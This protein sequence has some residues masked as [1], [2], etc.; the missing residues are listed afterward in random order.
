[1]I[2]FIQITNLNRTEITVGY[3]WLQRNSKILAEYDGIV[4]QA[5]VSKKDAI[6]HVPWTN[7]SNQP[8]AGDHSRYVKGSFPLWQPES[9][10]FKI[11]SLHIF[12]IFSDGT[13]TCIDT[14]YI[15]FSTDSVSA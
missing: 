8:G 10:L 6:V 11:P 2:E 7:L 13:Q 15:S 9:D 3:V 1:M 4:S 12:P 14:A 5:L